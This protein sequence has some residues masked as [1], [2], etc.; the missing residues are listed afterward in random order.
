MQKVI[1]FVGLCNIT[2]VLILP[3]ILLILT[4]IFYPAC[5][6]LFQV[7][8]DSWIFPFLTLSKHM[9]STWSTQYQVVR[10]ML[11]TIYG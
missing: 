7:L 9:I 3:S 5:L 10:V 4:F 1:V 11:F 2:L 8:T 6:L